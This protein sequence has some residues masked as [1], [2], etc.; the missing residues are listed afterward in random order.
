MIKKFFFG[1]YS[2]KISLYVH[3]SS[4]L[5]GMG[6]LPL[7]S[8]VFPS[9]FSFFFMCFYLL[10]LIF[11]MIGLLNSSINYIKEKKTNK[12]SAFNGYLSIIWII[13]L[14]FMMIKG[15][16][17]NQNKVY[18]KSQRSSVRR[19]FVDNDCSTYQCWCYRFLRLSLNCLILR[20]S[21]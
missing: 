1:E 10:T 19:T 21:Q 7:L 6:L 15:V 2:L 4:W 14:S 3:F 16:I 5:G 20:R 18:Y 12:Q 9:S 13:F 8:L 11:T 17:F